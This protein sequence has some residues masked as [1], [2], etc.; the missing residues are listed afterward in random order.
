M[1][2]SDG[3]SQRPQWKQQPQWPGMTLWPNNSQSKCFPKVILCSPWPFSL[4]QG[5]VCP[6][7]KRGLVRTETEEKKQSKTGCLRPVPALPFLWWGQRGWQTSLLI[8]KVV[9]AGKLGQGSHGLIGHIHSTVKPLEVLTEIYKWVYIFRIWLW[10]LRWGKGMQTAQ[11][12]GVAGRVKRLL[13]LPK[14]TA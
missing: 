12:V 4:P 10:V 7:A 5:E 8:V 3:S 6:H 13:S 9:L 2:W 11:G 14:T 1:A